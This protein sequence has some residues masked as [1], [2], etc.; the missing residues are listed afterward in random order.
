MLACLVEWSKVGDRPVDHR[1][2]LTA[3]PRRR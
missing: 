2:V 1:L 3:T